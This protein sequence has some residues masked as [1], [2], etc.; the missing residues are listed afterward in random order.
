MIEID[1]FQGSKEWKE[2]R[3]KRIGASDVAAIMGLSPFQTPYQKWL[4]KVEDVEQ[5]STFSMKRGTNREKEG[6]EY[7]EK[8][9]GYKVY[10]KVVQSREY[11]W[12]F[13]SLDGISQDETYMVEIKWANQDVHR[14]AKSGVVVDYYYTQCQAQ[15]FCVNKRSMDFLSC[16]EKDGDREF[17]LVSV[18]RDSLFQEKMLEKCSQFYH[19]HLLTKNPPPLSDKDYQVADDDSLELLCLD[20]ER[21]SA[22]IRKEEEIKKEI[23]EKIKERVDNRNTM[24]NLFKITKFKPK[25][26]IDY[27]AVEEL[28]NVD[29]EK[30]RKDSKEQWRIT[31]R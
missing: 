1:L 9:V 24:S 26:V 31:K 29:L 4:E 20:Y 14:M 7:Y 3:K 21:A 22:I 25:G 11:D 16:F 12:F 19:D 8:T 13:C 6:R 10:P 5:E 2:Y 28:K 18:T 15:L 30:Y 27:S 23:L 17:A